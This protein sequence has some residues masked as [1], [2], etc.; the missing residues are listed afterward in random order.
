MKVNRNDLRS[1]R[2][3]NQYLY[4]RLILDVYINNWSGSV[5]NK[6]FD[7]NFK[8]QR[9]KKEKKKPTRPNTIAADVMCACRSDKTA[10]EQNSQTLLRFHGGLI[11]K[12]RK[13][14]KSHE[15]KLSVS[16]SARVTDFIFNVLTL[17]CITVCMYGTS[18]I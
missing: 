4:G 5:A 9:G 18:I 10:A 16:S 15:M 14:K 11:I 8:F 12:K 17:R 3:R 13:S 7:R 2:S 1:T 6:T